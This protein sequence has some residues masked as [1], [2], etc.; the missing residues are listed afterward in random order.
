MSSA[1]RITIVTA[2]LV[3]VLTAILGV[4]GVMFQDWHARK[5][6]AGRRKLALEDARRQVSFATEWWSARKLLADSAEAVQEATDSAM[7]WLE[8]AS[9]RAAA[10]ELPAMEEKTRITFRR[11]M[12]FYRLQGMAANVIR[13]I[14]YLL[15]GL[16]VMFVGQTYYTIGGPS[17]YVYGDLVVLV[18]IFLVALGLRF[19]A[20]SAQ[21]STRKRRR[22]RWTTLRR[23]LLFYRLGRPAASLVRIIFYILAIFLIFYISQLV[24]D[25]GTDPHS[26][27]VDIT[28]FIAAA[29]YAVGLRYWAASLRATRADGRASQKFSSNIA[30]GITESPAGTVG[31]R[32]PDHRPDQNNS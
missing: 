24:E 10:S 13:G 18:V 26:L 11:L 32:F 7:P 8:Q 1:Q 30:A 31:S 28:F 4:L 17:R 14:F 22:V 25:I 23:A 16:S 27:P 20:V 21:S 6:Q 2:V 5:T 9:A 3:P 12:L 29:G 15:L 19:W